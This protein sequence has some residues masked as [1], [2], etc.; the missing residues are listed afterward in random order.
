MEFEV[1]SH[2]QGRP[3]PQVTSFIIS[4]VSYYVQNLM[5]Y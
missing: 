3:F 2:F 1:E 5:R 4:Q